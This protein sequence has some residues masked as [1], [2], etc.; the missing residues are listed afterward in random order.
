VDRHLAVLL[1][2]LAATA[3]VVAVPKGPLEFLPAASL[4]ALPAEVEGWI[5]TGEAPEQVLPDDP[6]AIESVRR[7]YENGGRVVLLAV[8]RYPSADPSRRP[9]LD[10][11]VADQGLGLATRDALVVRLNGAPESTITL[12]RLTW[13]RGTR[14]LTV[15]YWYE[16]G[17]AVIAG[18]YHLRVQLFLDSLRGRRRELAI[19]RIAG[20]S[21][22]VIAA[23]LRAVRPY[24]PRTA[25]RAQGAE[26]RR[27]APVRTRQTS[28]VSAAGQTSGPE[29][30]GGD[31]SWHFL[32]C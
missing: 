3:V 25:A 9:T 6:R 10:R 20:E 8:A 29:P 24:V 14:Q 1:A 31:R 15:L 22:D 16:L 32:D 26:D 27:G 2:I 30:A 18:D 21:L 5:A 19:V 4:P 13:R 17:G 7:R 12:N 28:R 11:L 23:F